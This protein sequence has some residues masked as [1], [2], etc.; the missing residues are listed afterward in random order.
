APAYYD[1]SYTVN[2]YDP[3]S[4]QVDFGHQETREGVRTSGS[5]HVLLPD[6]RIMKVEYYVD[7]TGFHPIY[8]YEGEAVYS[9]PSPSNL[10]STP[11][12]K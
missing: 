5:Y 2:D 12:K 6:T 9:Q 8:T 1:F 7:D 4:S 11:G 10:Y 3:Y